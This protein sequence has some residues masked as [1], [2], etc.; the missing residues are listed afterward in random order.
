M[1]GCA[2]H[3]RFEHELEIPVCGIDAVEVVY[4]HDQPRYRSSRCQELNARAL[5]EKQNKEI[6]EEVALSVLEIST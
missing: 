2:H 1:L 6:V 4:G 5:F 3:L